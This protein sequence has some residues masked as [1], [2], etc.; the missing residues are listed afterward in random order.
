MFMAFVEIFSRC[1]VEPFDNKMPNIHDKLSGALT[2]FPKSY[3]VKFIER[4]F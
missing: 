2:V 3:Q 1:Y 4:S